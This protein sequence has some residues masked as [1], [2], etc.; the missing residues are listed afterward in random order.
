M[1]VRSCLLVLFICLREFKRNGGMMGVGI[2]THA[3]LYLAKPIIPNALMIPNLIM[4][5]L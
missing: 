2:P 4:R 1:C 5:P 3:L